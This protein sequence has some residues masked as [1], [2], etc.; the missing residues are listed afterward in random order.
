MYMMFM[1]DTFVMYM[2][3][4]KLNKLASGPW[5]DLTT[6]TSIPRKTTSEPTEDSLFAD[7]SDEEEDVCYI[8]SQTSPVE[9]DPKKGTLQTSLLI[10]GKPVR[11]IL[12]SGSELDIICR[13]TAEALELQV[14]PTLPAMP[15][16]GISSTPLLSTLSY[17]TSLQLGKDQPL[18]IR[19]NVVSE[20]LPTLIS[21]RTQSD[22]GCKIDLPSKLLTSSFS[23]ATFPVTFATNTNT[24]TQHSVDIN[25][26]TSVCASYL[27]NSLVNSNLPT[28]F[29][30][31]FLLLLKEFSDIWLEPKAGK[32][33]S[34]IVNFKVRGKPKR[35]NPRPLSL[36]LLKEAHRQVDDLLA[37]GVIERQEQSTWA[38]PIVMV[39]KK[40]PDNED[41]WRMAVDYRYVNQLLLDDNY[42]LPVIRDLFNQLHN[43][44]FFSCVDLN[45]GFWNVKLHPDCKQFTAFT[46]PQKG[47]FVWNVLPFGM[48]TSPT[49]FQNAVESALRPLIDT[50]NVK[51][52]ID[53]III[54][55]ET[56]P[57]HLLFLRRVFRSLRDSGLYL[58]IQKSQFV[59]TS[60]KYLGHVISYNSIQPD[61]DKVANLQ[62]VPPPKDKHQ[63]RSFLGAAS[64]LRAFI[65]SF[66]KQLLL[67]TH[68]LLNEPYSRGLRI[69]ILL[70]KTLKIPLSIFPT[71]AFQT[72]LSPTLCSVT[73]VM[74]ALE[75][76]SL[77]TS[78]IT[79]NSIT[80]SL[81]VNYSTI[82][83]DVGPRLRERF[84]LLCGPAKPLKGISKVYTL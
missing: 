23:N 10:N 82:L 2:K 25:T 27:E 26:N 47:I 53:D 74:S 9:P 14:D 33:T 66:L 6:T 31:E 32:C 22:L 63:L 3:L 19:F 49:E 70:S 69:T 34:I 68:C 78:K 72:L 52:Y 75:P 65:P 64:Y 20:N 46:V 40:S 54:A 71:L 50:G 38:S 37:S 55:T 13:A 62:K 30:D 81:L 77:S 73:Q 67:S 84:M 79:L 18:L 56:I 17:P 11:V 48:K 12:D 36:P 5:G 51:V 45:W 60:V 44:K 4:N 42:P 59:R 61:P 58:N 15:I 28:S 1:C 8:T 76:Y 35:F 39:R 7:Y 57:S 24:L 80:F 83:N 21:P 16:Y 43:Y 29:H 41:R